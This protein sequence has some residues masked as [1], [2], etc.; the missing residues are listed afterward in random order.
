MMVRRQDVSPGALCVHTVQGRA[1]RDL[2]G[3]RKSRLDASPKNGGFRPSDAEMAQPD[4]VVPDW[5]EVARPFV[6]ALVTDVVHH[7]G[8]K[9][10]RDAGPSS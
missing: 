9:N 3:N 1:G 7:T 2:G 5:S 8:Q 6:S 4:Q 10:L